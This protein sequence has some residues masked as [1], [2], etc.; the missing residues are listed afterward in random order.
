MAEHLLP[1]PTTPHVAA[2]FKSSLSHISKNTKS[3]AHTKWGP[4]FSLYACN[5]KVPLCER[6]C[7]ISAWERLGAEPGGRVALDW[8]VRKN[9]DTKFSGH[10]IR[11]EAISP[12]LVVLQ[13]FLSFQWKAVCWS[14]C[15]LYFWTLHNRCLDTKQVEILTTSHFT[16]K[17][18]INCYFLYHLQVGEEKKDSQCKILL[19]VRF[20]IGPTAGLLNSIQYTIC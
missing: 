1:V 18:K 10:I 14:E 13:K 19:Y 6:Y 20:S 9:N 3:S 7:I 11:E 17:I 2:L 8:E 5:P 15:T 16:Y 4:H 12:S